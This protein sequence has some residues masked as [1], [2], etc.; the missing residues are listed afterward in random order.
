MRALLFVGLVGL[1]GCDEPDPPDAS[2]SVCGDGPGTVRVGQGGSALR[3]LPATGGEL[4][5]VLGAQGGIHVLVGF[6][7]ADMELEMLATYTLSEVGTEEQLGTTLLSLRPSLFSTELGQT[8]RNPD[9][10]V[11]D[12]EN[13][14]VDRFAGRHASLCLEAVSAGSHACDCREITLIAPE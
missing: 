8:V 11:L 10:V 9:L 1:V 3:P 4:P 7:V 14:T 13:P 2:T 6:A 5:I 12:N